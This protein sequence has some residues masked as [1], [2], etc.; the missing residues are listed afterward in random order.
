MINPR[1]VLFALLVALACPALSTAGEPLP[2]DARVKSGKL[3]NGVTWMYRQHNVPPGKMALMIHVDAGSLS[4]TEEQRG[5][6]HFIEHMAFNGSENFP[7]GQ[8]IPYFESIGMQFGHDLNAFTSFDQTVYMV[9]LPDT[10]SEQVDK[11]LTVL[12]DYAFRLS[13]PPD[14][15]D[16][17]RGVILEE[18]RAGE[19]AQQRL[20]DQLFEKLFVD[21]RLGK[22]LPI[23]LEKVIKE[24]QRPEFESFYR[25]WYRPE[26][27]T[28]M[29]VGD[30]PPEPYLPLIEKW[31]GQAKSAGEN[32]PDQGPELKPFAKER[33]LVLADAEYDQGDVDI[34]NISPGRPPTTTLEQAR[35]DLIERIGTWIMDRRFSERIKKGQASFREANARVASFF[36]D[37]MLVNAATVGEPKDWEKML[38]ELTTEVSRAREYGFMDGEF[39]LCKKELLS[40]AE[41]D[42]RKEPTRN[43]QGML[44]EMLQR[45]NEREPLLSAEQELDVLKKLLPT[46]KLD[47]VNKAIG[48][49]FKPG[50]FAFVLTLP[51]RD[52]VK[53]PS[54]EEVL[55]AARGPGPQA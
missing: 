55:A 28:L 18:L 27:I 41:D 22:R 26:R 49:H 36:N 52:D 51:K 29:I 54:E 42:V 32:K 48:E 21:T 37:A 39:D 33:A 45:V 2:R 34:Y 15:I 38:D 25:T 9:F 46:V 50:T 1:P 23:G 31:F 44:F 24:A 40:S 11:G 8:L 7:P 30:A 14:E 53:L 16:K 35:V 6:A 43:A 47:E 4:E 17:E 20:R 19:G 3:G 12:S 13:L 5:L 10:T